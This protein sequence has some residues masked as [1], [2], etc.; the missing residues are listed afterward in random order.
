MA[1]SDKLQLQFIHHCYVPI[2]IDSPFRITY[3]E[4]PILALYLGVSTKF[5]RTDFKS[6]LSILLY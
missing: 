4:I 5:T 6:S 3:N 2:I 1:F